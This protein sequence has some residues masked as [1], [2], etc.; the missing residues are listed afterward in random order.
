MDTQTPPNAA[1]LAELRGLQDEITGLMLRY[2][3][4]FDACA[5]I[6]FLDV[7]PMFWQFGRF[8][9]WAFCLDLAFL[10][11]YLDVPLYP[12]RKIFGWPKKLLGRVFYRVV[13]QPWRS[14]WSGELPALRMVRMRYLTRLLLFYHAQARIDDLH[15]AFNARHLQ[16]LADRAAD[17][18]IADAAANLQTAFDL[19]DQLTK[20]KY[21]IGALVVFGPLI[22]LMT[23]VMQKIVL[24]L[25]Q[26]FVLPGLNG[27]LVGTKAYVVVQFF[28]LFNL[29]GVF[30]MA[31]FII[32]FAV[33]LVISVWIDGQAL[34][35]GLGLAAAEQRAGAALGLTFGPAPPVD[36]LAFLLISA[37]GAAALLWLQYN[38]TAAIAV[39]LAAD[40]NSLNGWTVICAGCAALAL[41]ALVRRIG[42]PAWLRP[43]P[44]AA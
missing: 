12:L 34:L 30:G 38:P 10:A 9:I 1:M 13:M 28:G 23:L 17:A 26:N 15:K 21:Q 2:N 29:Q 5:A 6:P 37:A 33:F 20:D 7:R 43:K 3:Q 18:E 39:Q 22:T 16:W 31:A 14:A 27:L 8:F 41:L 24:P 32:F 35:R 40:P 44:A 11:A 4:A 36:L 42:L 25:L 19:F